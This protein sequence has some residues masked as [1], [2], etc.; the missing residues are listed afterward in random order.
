ML[1]GGLA[2]LALG[3]AVV[4]LAAYEVMPIRGVPVENVIIDLNAD[5]RPDFLITGLVI[6]GPKAEALPA[7]GQP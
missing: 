7:A 2:G 5:G 4:G 6:Y 1:V 3:G